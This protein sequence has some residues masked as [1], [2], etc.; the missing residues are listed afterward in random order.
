MLVLL[1]GRVEVARRPDAEPLDDGSV[2]VAL[3]P[4]QV[5]EH[6]GALRDEHDEASLSILVLVVPFHVLGQLL[7]PSREDSHLHLPRARV[8]RRPLPS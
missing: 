8:A 5:L 7:D 4:A 1:Q 3:L 6:L 2:P